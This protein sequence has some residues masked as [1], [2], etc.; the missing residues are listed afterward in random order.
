MALKRGFC[1]HCQGDEIQRIFNVNKEA[2]ICYCPVCAHPMQP[3][4]AIVNYNYVTIVCR[5]CREMYW[6][7]SITFFIPSW[8]TIRNKIRKNK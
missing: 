8:T 1:T 5:I 4:D 3:K 6:T 7:I 2:E